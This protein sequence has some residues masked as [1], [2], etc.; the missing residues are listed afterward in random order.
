MSGE[1]SKWYVHTAKQHQTEQNQ[2]WDKQEK[3]EEKW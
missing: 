3:R 1:K 2:N